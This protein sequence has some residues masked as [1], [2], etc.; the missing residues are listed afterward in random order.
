MILLKEIQGIHLVSWFPGAVTFG[1]ALPLYEILEHSG[2]YVMS[3]VSNLFHFVLFL[4]I[5]QVRWW[6]GVIWTVGIYLDIWSKKGCV[7]D[8]MNC[9]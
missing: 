7:E 6:P 4:I 2:V 8:W 5:D 3:V 1:I 9:P